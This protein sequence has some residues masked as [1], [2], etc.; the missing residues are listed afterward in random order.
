MQL[1]KKHPGMYEFLRI[2]EQ[3]NDFEALDELISIERKHCEQGVATLFDK[4][5]W[6]RFQ[7]EY[8]R[9]TIMNLITWVGE[10][11]LAHLPKTTPTDEVYS[12]VE[13]YLAILK[14]VLYKP[15]YL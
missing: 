9:S 12:E 14:K 7:E 11:C 5:D 15:E 13:R 4:V 10:G 8:D 3:N 1:N 6:S 2:D